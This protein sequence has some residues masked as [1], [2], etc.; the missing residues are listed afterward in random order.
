[1]DAET[2]KQEF[3][4]DMDNFVDGDVFSKGA[5]VGV[6][7][8]HCQS[9]ADYRLVL[10]ALTGKTSSK[11]LTPAE[12]F[13]LLEFVKPYKIMGVGRWDTQREDLGAACSAL[14]RSTYDV[15]EQTRFA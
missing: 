3:K 7:K 6:L 5:I 8:K 9:D 2:I 4:Q 10:K 12:W 14:V 11:L 13:A 1:M 15:P